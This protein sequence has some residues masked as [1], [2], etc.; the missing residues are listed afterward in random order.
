MISQ[1]INVLIACFT[2]L[3]MAPAYATEEPAPSVASRYA[4]CTQMSH[5][6]PEEAFKTAQKWF[7]ESHSV[8]AE[9]CMALSLFEMR[10]YRGAANELERILEIITPSQGK[11]WLN[12]KLQTAKSYMLAENY[13][14]AE[15]HLTEA[16]RW[17]S[18]QGNLDAEMSP[19]LIQRS[20]IYA[21]HNEHLRAV[22]DLDHALAIAPSADVLLE[23]A[24][25]FIKLRKI[26]S[27]L[28]DIKAV[29]KAEPM[30]DD[31]SKL[32]S[33]V[34]RRMDEMAKKK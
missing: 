8:A 32:L 33:I 25:V 20:R 24:R 3:G 1:K 19:L 28:D 7:K 22:N 5:T 12:M 31:A 10:D 9:H 30:N 4:D 2:L 29:L 11:L 21:L 27:A 14:P 17:A 16:L 18:D 13:V 26:D 6:Q 34:E 23:R 15:K